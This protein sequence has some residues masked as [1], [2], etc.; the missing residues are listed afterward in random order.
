MATKKPV[1]KNAKPAP[2]KAVAKKAPA[3]KAAAKKP[4][5]RAAVKRTKAVVAPATTGDMGGASA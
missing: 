4:A 1:A 3:K 5:K 2:K